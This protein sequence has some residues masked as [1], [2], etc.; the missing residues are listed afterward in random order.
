MPI[1]S[2]TGPV[3]V[4][5]NVAPIT[6][7]PAGGGAG[8][9]GGAQ[10]AAAAVIQAAQAAN[11]RP[12]LLG[13]GMRGPRIKVRRAYSRVWNDITGAELCFD[14]IWAGQEALIFVDLTWWDELIYQS[15]AG[16]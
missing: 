2:T 16:F 1:P 4:Y 10:A 11:R 6:A 13:T 8:V 14:K 5:L 7:S 15:L 3:G 12:R 9:V